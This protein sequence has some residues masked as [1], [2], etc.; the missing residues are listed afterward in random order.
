MQ[1]AH[2]NANTLHLDDVVTTVQGWKQPRLGQKGPRPSK[3]HNLAK[4][5]VYDLS[6]QWLSSVPS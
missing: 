2:H 1:G 4:H 6:I 5:D 3:E